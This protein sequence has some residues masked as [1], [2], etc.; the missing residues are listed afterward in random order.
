M[1]EQA[2]N[3][4][5]ALRAALLLIAA[6]LAVVALL[7]MHSVA[8]EASTTT[9]ASASSSVLP[10]SLQSAGHISGVAETSPEPGEQAAT[11]SD[12]I[13][14]GSDSPRVELCPCPSD[15]GSSMTM[16]ECTPVAALAGLVAVASLRAECAGFAPTVP[17]AS[18]SA[19]VLVH[20][21]TPSLHALSISR[22]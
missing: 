19:G 6:L 12:V 7:M 4:V 15:S 22:T 8:A 2:T 5:R 1:T 18:G 13:P 9:A 10:G 14:H 11:H 17:A 3:V 16:A 20:A 21:Q